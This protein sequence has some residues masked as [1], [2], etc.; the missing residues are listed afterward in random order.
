MK[1]RPFKFQPELTRTL[2][3]E[4]TKSAYLKSKLKEKNYE[5]KSL[6]EKLD[7]TIALYFAASGNGDIPELEKLWYSFFCFDGG[8]LAGWLAMLFKVF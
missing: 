3:E 7:E 8:W 6:T 1:Q 2:A 4:K 5:I